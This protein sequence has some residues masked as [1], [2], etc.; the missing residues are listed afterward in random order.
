MVAKRIK[1]FGI[2]VYNDDS[3]S[4]AFVID[5]LM[6]CLGYEYTQAANCAN[7]IH[8]NGAYCVKSFGVKDLAKVQDITELIIKHGI[9]ADY[10]PIA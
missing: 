5:A 9:K 1:K 10:R 7:L 2:F 8:N 3:N 4:F 6:N